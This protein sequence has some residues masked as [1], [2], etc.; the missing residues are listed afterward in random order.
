MEG[1]PRQ[2]RKLVSHLDFDFTIESVGKF[3]IESK[4][5]YFEVKCSEFD[6]GIFISFSPSLV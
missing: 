6:L 3:R 5:V 2:S 4:E 1:N